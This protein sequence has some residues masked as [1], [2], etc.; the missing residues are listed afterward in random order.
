[1][2]G[3]TGQIIYANHSI[4]R[5]IERAY[6]VR[7]FQITG[8]DWLDNVR[9]DI[10][11]KYPTGATE[12]DK[13]LMLRTLLGERFQLKVHRESKELQGYA[14]VAVKSGF[15]LQPVEPGGGS[16]T[17]ST[18]GAIQTLTAKRISI[19]ALADFLA[20]TLSE[21]VVDKSGISGVY[22]L[23]LRW[24]ADDLNKDGDIVAAAPNLVTALQDTLGLRLQPQKVPVKIIAVD[25]VERLPTDNF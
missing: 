25:H 7:S 5:L 24:S 1:M 8:P 3:S 21:T 9:F 10:I 18:G 4:K 19:T 6:R 11:A 22:N 13:A 23:E 2:H 17:S 15:K 20:G 14:L 16:E 12:K